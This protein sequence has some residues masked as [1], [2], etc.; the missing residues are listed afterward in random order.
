MLD[1]DARAKLANRIIYIKVLHV[2]LKAI[3]AYRTRV[4]LKRAIYGQTGASI[5]QEH[6][7][8]RRKLKRRHN[9]SIINRGV[10]RIGNIGTPPLYS[11]IL[12][13]LVSISKRRS[14]ETFSPFLLVLGS[15]SF[16]KHAVDR[17]YALVALEK[18]SFL[19]NW[20]LWG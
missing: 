4:N 19:S 14:F 10:G 17:L 6:Q 15:T 8:S 5:K 9:N 18:R 12:N 3:A 11:V 16:I 7:A 1:I 2:Y 13:A 20:T